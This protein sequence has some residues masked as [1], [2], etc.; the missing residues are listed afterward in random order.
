R[1]LE[2]RSLLVSAHGNY[3]GISIASKE[4]KLAI[5]EKVNFFLEKEV[6]DNCRY[7]D[8]WTGLGDRYYELGMVDE[9]V[10]AYRRAMKNSPNL[11]KSL[12]ANS[13][14]GKLAG[15]LANALFQ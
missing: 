8:L 6:D 9:A 4:E 14:K 11:V 7:C 3:E 15:E 13:E 12:R 10:E 1:M 2:A 5:L